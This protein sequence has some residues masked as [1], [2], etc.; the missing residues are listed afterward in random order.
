VVSL[1]EIAK[2]MEEGQGTGWRQYALIGVGIIL[3]VTGAVV[4]VSE[5]RGEDLVITEPMATPPPETALEIVVI[6]IQGAVSQPGVYKLPGG[7]RIVEGIM[8]AGG[9]STRADRVYIAQAINQAEILRDGMK[10]YL[11]ALGER[12][13]E[14]EPVSGLSGQV[15]GLISINKASESELTALTGIGPARAQAIIENRPYTTLEELIT[16]AKIPASVF[17][18]NRD[19]LSL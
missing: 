19:Q 8:A 5:N 4:A 18:Q 15:G 3:L 14:P 11:P 16:K 9:L 6:D 1:E 7:S 10:L 2:A 13:P 17:E 12:P